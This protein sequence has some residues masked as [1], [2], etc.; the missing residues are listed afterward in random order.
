[1]ITLPIW[2]YVQKLA[3][4]GLLPLAG[5][6][7]GAWVFHR[8]DTGETPV[9]LPEVIKVPVSHEEGQNGVVPPPHQR[10]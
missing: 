10:I 3:L 8:G 6:L 5:V 4:I 2:L 9:K 1:V 7:T